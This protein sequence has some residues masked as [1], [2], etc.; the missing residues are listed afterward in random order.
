MTLHSQSDFSGGLNAKFD[1]T[2]IAPN[3]YPLGVNVRVRKNTV[4]AIRGHLPL[5]APVGTKNGIFALGSVVVLFSG[6]AAYY[7]DVASTNNNFSAIGGWTAMDSAAEVFAQLTPA[8]TN[9]YV[10]AQTDNVAILKQT[11]PGTIASFPQALFVQS[12]SGVDRPQRINAN[13]AA[14]PLG[15]YSDWTV[16]QP[17]YVPIGRQ[18][19]VVGNKLFLV[20][21]D[22]ATVFSSVTGRCNDF[23][24]NVDVDGVIAGSADTVAAAATFD[25]ATALQSADNGT[26]ILC[27]L[28]GTF[29]FPLDYDNTV[30]GEPGLRATPLF[31]VGCV[32]QRSFARL[33]GD[34]A[35]ISQNGIQSFNVVSQSLTESNNDP[36]GSKIRDIMRNPQSETAAENYDNY[37]L[38]SV[39]TR[40]GRGTAVFDTT[41]G[42]F[43]SIDLS[44]AHVTQF[45]VVKVSGKE[46]IFF[47]DADD[48]VYEA[49]A[50]P[51]VAT[52]QIY[53]GE[54]TSQT[55]NTLVRVDSCNLI[56][57]DINQSGRVR[58]S[59]IVDGEERY[60]ATQELAASEM[61]T[62][63]DT[64]VPYENRINTRPV[65]FRFP[66]VLVG[67]KVGILIQW[68]ADAALSN[69]SVEGDYQTMQNPTRTG[70]ELVET[71][72]F[73]FVG[74]TPLGPE[75]IGGGDEGCIEIPPNRWY[76]FNPRAHEVSIVVGSVKYTDIA[77]VYITTTSIFVTGT[78]GSLRDCTNLRALRTAILAEK[79]TAVLGTGDH[80][81]DEGSAADVAD[82]MAF[83]KS[84]EYAFYAVAG[85]IEYDTNDAA[86]WWTALG[87]Q[88]YYTKDFTDVRFV[89]Y[90]GGWDS[91]NVGLPAGSTSEP[92]GND[93]DS[94]QGFWARGVLRTSSKRFNFVIVHE[95]PYSI[96]QLNFP[97]WTDL[98][99]TWKSYGADAVISGHDYAYW[100]ISRGG[101]VYINQ[102]LSGTSNTST[103][104]SLLTTDDYDAFTGSGFT[105]TVLEIDGVVAR[106]TTKSVLTGAVV[107]AHT[108]TV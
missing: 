42:E 32:N 20:S 82:V 85:N 86:A 26:V 78:G 55:P 34:T 13:F 71:E 37:A 36:V 10:R 59:V 21:P 58:I 9:S 29:Q 45:A 24:V 50:A 65:S 92:N 19:A 44:F 33:L 101:L 73:I 95:P 91:A 4:S 107:D 67:W 96:T 76:V 51:N 108:I 61:L 46:R 57:T 103:P 79:P 35:F 89:F 3:E 16:D 98:R 106:F 5:A 15:D 6:G 94:V 83:L 80:A 31:P 27:T 87:T 39:N 90:N 8:T 69:A 88:R 84:N 100:R 38:F 64:D 66:G 105:Y 23:G 68:T 41:I 47:I 75:I 30:F 93:P 7:L 1:P 56:F 63:N 49:F 77:V 2:K 22:G 53:I 102:G 28:H 62:V 104:Y 81:Y 70:G 97:G 14:S 54:L 18:M 12:A 43:V 52:A 99:L 48:N 11:F 60:T 74:N 25:S 40:Y 17:E 72:K